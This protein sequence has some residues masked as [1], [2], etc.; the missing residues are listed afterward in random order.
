[1]RRL[2]AP[3]ESPGF[4]EPNLADAALILY[5]LNCSGYFLEAAAEAAFADLESALTSGC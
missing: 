2:E 5:S 3:A 4:G 1:M